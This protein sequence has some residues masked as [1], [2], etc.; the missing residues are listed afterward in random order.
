MSLDPAAARPSKPRRRRG[1]DCFLPFVGAAW[2]ICLV[3]YAF[4]WIADPYALR[5]SRTRA[6]LAEHAYPENVVP[7]LFPIA[8]AEGADVVVVG[9]SSARGYTPAMIERAFPEAQR[10]VNLAYGCSTAADYRS[11]LPRLESSKRLKRVIFSLD[12]TLIWP[13]IAHVTPLDQRYYTLPWNEPVPEFGSQSVELSVRSRLTGVLDLPEWRQQLSD[14]VDN[15]T[16]LAPLTQSPA[17]LADVRDGLDY[18]HGQIA[19]AGEL[20]CDVVPSVRQLIAPF[21]QRLSRRGVAVDILSPPYSLAYYTNPRTGHSSAETFAY[22]MALRRCTLQ[23]TAGLPNVRFH[24]FDADPSI[25]GQLSNY[26]DIAHIC[27]PSIDLAILRHIAAGDHVL[28]PSRW[29][30]AEASLRREL[31]DFRT[32]AAPPSG[33]P[34]DCV[35]GP[36]PT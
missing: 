24:F 35:A 16:D 15:I 3:C 1:R 29:P 12:F 4:V 20:S 19:S 13:C 30:A 14:R 22:T 2:L 18:M 6:H 26:G 21:V 36:P 11:A 32:A 8:A 31:L 27:S 17:A 10:P 28:T 23:M 25:T 5:T 9:A 7:R 34:Q 33:A